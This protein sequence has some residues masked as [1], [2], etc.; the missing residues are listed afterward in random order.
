MDELEL[1]KIMAPFYKANPNTVGAGLGLSICQH[2]IDLHH[3]EFLLESKRG[4]GMKASFSIPF[5]SH[6]IGE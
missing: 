3:G 1:E 5:D 6:E 2:I 4:E